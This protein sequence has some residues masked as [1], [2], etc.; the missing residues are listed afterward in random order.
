MGE[1]V[2]FLVTIGMRGYHGEFVAMLALCVLLA[3][4]LIGL[5][6]VLVYRKGGIALFCIRGC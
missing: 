2:G 1:L 4:Y 6:G 5:E 3:I